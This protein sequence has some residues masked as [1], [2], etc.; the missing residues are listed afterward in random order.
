MFH[1]PRRERT[2]N[3]NMYAMDDNG[4]DVV[5]VHHAR[6]SSEEEKELIT[7]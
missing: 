1:K 2:L 6:R 7:E 5:G 3:I 4:D